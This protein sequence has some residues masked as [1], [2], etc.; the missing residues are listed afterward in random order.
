MR[1]CSKWLAGWSNSASRDPLRSTI[2]SLGGFPA[3]RAEK[4]LKK[5][6][7]DFDPQYIVL[8]FGATDAQC[9]IR[10]GS[11]L[12]AN[13]NSSPSA[14]LTTASY[15]GQPATT[16]SPLRWQLA[17]V[18]GHLRR[19]EPIT[20][21]SAYITAIERMVDDCRS[22]GIRAVVLSPFVYGARYTMRKAIF[23]VDA[24]RELHSR[25]QD[26]IFVDCVRLLADFPK[27]RILQ[28]DGFHLSRLGQNLVGEAIGKAIVEDVE[29]IVTGRCIVD[30]RRQQL[31]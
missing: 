27:S 30:A 15:R 8:Q 25:A 17:S 28:H 24:L 21:L 2:V 6:L 4:Y 26:M 31:S 7:F 9:P 18:I 19:T 12:N 5:K 23:Y 14:A 3:P 13:N 16:F 11:R 20:P 29:D 10:A 1:G 22:A